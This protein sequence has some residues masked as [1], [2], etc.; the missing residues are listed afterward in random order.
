MVPELVFFHHED[1]R[2][3]SDRSSERKLLV[4]VVLN[5][6]SMQLTAVKYVTWVV[7]LLTN[8]WGVIMIPP[9][10]NLNPIGA[11]RSVNWPPLPDCRG[12][13]SLPSCPVY[14]MSHQKRNRKE[15]FWNPGQWNQVPDTIIL[16]L[17]RLFQL[18][19]VF[20]LHPGTQLI[21]FSK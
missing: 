10:R 20:C 13:L 8:H 12:F 14:S 4:T 7:T 9:I 21:K 5:L 19:L 6:T 17:K 11:A 18:L 15:I 16:T 2:E 1:R 3:E